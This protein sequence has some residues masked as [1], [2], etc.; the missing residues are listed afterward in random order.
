MYSLFIIFINLFVASNVNA[1]TRIPIA[2]IDTGIKSNSNLEPYI[3]KDG[4][5]DF[6]NTGIEDTDGHGTIVA[7]LIT[8]NLNKNKYCILILKWTSGNTGLNNPDNILK[9]IHYSIF[10]DAKFINMSLSGK[11]YLSLEKKLIEI[12]IK[13][14]ATVVVAAGNNDENLKETC[15]VYPACYNIDHKNFRVVANYHNNGYVCRSNFNGP[16]TDKEDGYYPKTDAGTSCGTS[17]AAAVLTSK[18]AK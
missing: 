15:N 13:L 16:I 6:T 9:S 8:K 2:I 1:E 10:M 14:G 18:L 11:L 4:K 3:C 12:A 7:K 5:H 17:M